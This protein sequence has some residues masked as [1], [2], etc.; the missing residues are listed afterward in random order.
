MYVSFGCAP[1][2]GRKE[3]NKVVLAYSGGLDT[4]VILKW[5]IEQDFDVV[6]YIADVGQSEDLVAAESKALR[7][8]ASQVF[9]EDLKQE[10]IESYVF[11]ALKGG[12]IYEGRY[13]LGT[14]IARPV[15]AKRQI[16]IATQVGA[17]YVSHGATGKGNDQVRFELASY[18][19]APG[20]R[21]IAPW[22]DARFLEQFKGRPDLLAYAKQHGIEVETNKEK[23]PYSMDANLMHISYEGGILEDPMTP[24]PP[25]MFRLTRDIEDAPDSAAHISI[26][27]AAG[28]PVAVVDSSTGSRVKGSLEL[29]TYLNKLGGEHGVGRI[30]IVENRYV[31]IKSRGVYETPGASILWAAHRD[32]ELICLDRQVLRL[33]EKLALELADIIYNG[34]WFSAEMEFLQAATAASQRYVNGTVHVKLH[35]GNIIVEGRESPNSLYNPHIASMDKEGGYDQKDAA[36]FI[37]V[38]SVRLAAFQNMKKQIANA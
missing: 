23:P 11:E 12:A 18:A 34:Y 37:R 3:M 4:S 24:P 30:D 32:L 28:V 29:F 20:L 26:E 16:E 5:L 36:G 14:S 22:K 10:F 19:L 21:V 9:V 8:G 15:I 33:K 27:F 2:L 35:K 6:A 17:Q 7:C 1:K 13:L 31:G 25:G 38:N